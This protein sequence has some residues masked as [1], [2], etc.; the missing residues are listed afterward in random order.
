M[1][2]RPRVVAAVIAIAWL[3]ALAGAAPTHRPSESAK[4][5][6]RRLSDVQ[7]SSARP[8]IATVDAAVPAL[9]QSATSRLMQ[10]SKLRVQS[11]FNH[12][13]SAC[14][15]RRRHVEAERQPLPIFCSLA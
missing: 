1:I 7:S 8:P 4:G 5:H 9:L 12:L 10:R 3:G 2:G 14:E 6:E 15:Q 11:S 13:T